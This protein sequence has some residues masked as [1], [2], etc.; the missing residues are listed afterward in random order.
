MYNRGF[1]VENEPK[2]RHA[3]VAALGPTIKKYEITAVSPEYMLNYAR[4][5]DFMLFM[6]LAETYAIYAPNRNAMLFMLLRWN[7][8]VFNASIIGK[9]LIVTCLRFHQEA[10]QESLVTS[11]YSL[12]TK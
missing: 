8:T 12:Y 9:S 5:V 11:Y 7:Y 4:D 2:Y 6:P 10:N 3:S 1:S